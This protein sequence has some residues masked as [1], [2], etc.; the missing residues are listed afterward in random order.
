V[1]LK[2]D[3]R[4][5]AEFYPDPRVRAQLHYAFAHRFL[6]DYAHRH[7]LNFVLHDGTDPSRFVQARWQMFERLSGLQPLLGPTDDGPVFRRVGDLTASAEE[8]AGYPAIL[9]QMP[10]PEE[11]AGAFFVMVVLLTQL[12]PFRALEASLRQ[13][14]AHSGPRVDE[15]LVAAL[16]LTP[17]RYFTL[18]R[19]AALQGTERA[20]TVGSFCEWIP[21]GLHHN[22]G[23]HLPVRRDAFVKA[24]SH[25]LSRPLAPG[26]HA[27][28]V[29]RPPGGKASSTPQPPE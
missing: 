16:R 4:T 9:I 8:I 29:P 10:M 21:K 12:E 1:N 5:L 25:A 2:E 13:A 7:P 24:A 3:I 6:P 28:A 17:C 22:F 20:V 18:E 11:S 15:S 14:M 23:L 26:P 27:A 19:S